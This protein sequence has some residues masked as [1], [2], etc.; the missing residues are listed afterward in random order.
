[1]ENIK[2]EFVKVYDFD[3]ILEIFMKIIPSWIF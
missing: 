3:L 2:L 1:M